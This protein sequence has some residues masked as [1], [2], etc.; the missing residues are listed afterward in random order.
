MYIEKYNKQTFVVFHD[1]TCQII[2]ELVKRN[3]DIENRVIPFSN[4]MLLEGNIKTLQEM[5]EK[6]KCMKITFR[7]C[8]LT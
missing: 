2:S 3:M 6:M 5:K 4:Y 1:A 7:I 8:K